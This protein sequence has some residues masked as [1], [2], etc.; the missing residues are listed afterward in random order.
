MDNPIAKKKSLLWLLILFSIFGCQSH[1]DETTKGI[2]VYSKR[3]NDDCCKKSVS[4]LVCK[5]TTPEMDARKATILTSLRKQML[6]KEELPNGY[7]FK[8]AGT[9]TMI[10]ELTEFAKTERHCCDFFTF[11]LSISGDTSAVW[12]EITGPLEAK[13]FITTELEL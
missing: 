7:A 1:A 2:P 6:D 9:D 13:E 10:N 8:F 3:M 11:K 5:L 12:F 4:E